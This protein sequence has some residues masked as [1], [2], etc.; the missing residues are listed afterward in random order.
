MNREGKHTGHLT[1][2]TIRKYLA[3][4]LSSAAMHEIETHLLDCAFCAD[5]VDGFELSERA[6]VKTDRT[7]LAL[8]KKLNQRIREHERPR[9]IR[10]PAWSAAAAGI[11]LAI[12]GYVVIKQREKEEQLLA[13]QQ[14][15]AFLEAGPEDTLIIFLPEAPDPISDQ[16][17]IASN[18][19]SGPPGRTSRFAPAPAARDAESAADEVLA[20]D[21]Q[22]GAMEQQAEINA[23]AD[24]T[25]KKAAAETLAY[26]R[27]TANAPAQE[28]AARARSEVVSRPVIGSEAYKKYLTDSLQYPAE[29]LEHRI[30]GE[31]VIQF[32]VRPSG[33]PAAFEVVSSL[34]YGCDQEAIRLIDEGP[35]WT[36]PVIKGQRQ[37][38]RV[39][40]TVRFTLP[41]REP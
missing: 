24:N 5:A 33:R 25:P 13:I 34:G 19:A 38:A 20:A 22:A 26:E 27:L 21:S 23:A 4:Q 14:S 17:L 3:G 31:V 12:A 36:N 6:Q 41:D 2:D 7:L 35:D 11:A 16:R 8:R 40:Q 30:E 10:W 29:A 9:V 28:K 32:T 1:P 18:T 39:S 37:P 15:Q